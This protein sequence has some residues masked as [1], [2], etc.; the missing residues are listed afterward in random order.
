MPARDRAMDRKPL[1]LGAPDGLWFRVRWLCHDASRDAERVTEGIVAA[2][3]ADDIVWDG[4]DGGI[5]WGWVD[6]LTHLAAEWRR[7]LL[8]EMDP[9]GLAQP[10]PGRLRA[11]AERRW[12]AL[13]VELREREDEA[14]CRFERAHDLAAGL[15]GIDAPPFWF[16]R[17]GEAVIA[18][19]PSR[20]RE[21]DFRGALSALAAFVPKA[22]TR[23]G[24]LRRISVINRS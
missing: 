3:I 10:D 24:I 6:L 13:P 11:E 2:G 17:Q 18:G 12:E 15:P 1:Q 14:L 23:F 7:L 19:H 4:S 9:L 8:E 21:L 22:S 20:L 5:H 16:L